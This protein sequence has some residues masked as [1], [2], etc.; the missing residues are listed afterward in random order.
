MRLWCS[1]AG[2]TGRTP[3]TLAG[4]PPTCRT[5][6]PEAGDQILLHLHHVGILEFILLPDPL[7]DLLTLKV[8]DELF[9]VIQGG[10]RGHHQYRVGGLVA[11][12]LNVPGID[13]ELARRGRILH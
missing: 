10:L 5:A 6:F 12:E 4:S 3:I 11:G 9:D 1:P 7:R 8:V 13:T 2:T